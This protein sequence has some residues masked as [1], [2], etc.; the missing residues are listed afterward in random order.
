M[1]NCPD[2]IEYGKHRGL[3]CYHCLSSPHTYH[4]NFE[5]EPKKGEQGA[6]P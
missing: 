3:T 5:E 1:R 6:Y 2:C 4:P